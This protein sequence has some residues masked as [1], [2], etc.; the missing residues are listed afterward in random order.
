MATQQSVAT[1]AQQY[2]V[3]LP[4]LTQAQILH[5]DNND[6]MGEAQKRCFH[7]LLVALEES[8]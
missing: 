1:A 6:Y 3:P 2:R 7:G 5:M 8:L 4:E